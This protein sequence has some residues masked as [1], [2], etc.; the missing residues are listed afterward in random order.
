MSPEQTGRLAAAGPALKQLLTWTGS[1]DPTITSE[2]VT[3]MAEFNLW[4]S[5]ARQRPDVERLGR[6][7]FDLGSSSTRRLAALRLTQPNRYR[8]MILR[9]TPQFNPV[10]AQSSYQ[11][12]I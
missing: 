12:D 9:Q 3:A 5:L 6:G 7:R 1:A 11:K 10:Q 8:A 4:I 2:A